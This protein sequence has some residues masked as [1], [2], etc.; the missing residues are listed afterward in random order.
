MK[1]HLCQVNSYVYDV[2]FIGF[3]YELLNVTILDLTIAKS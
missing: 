1:H 3:I 2:I